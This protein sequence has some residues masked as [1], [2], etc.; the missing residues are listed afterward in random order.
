MHTAGVLAVKHCAADGVSMEVL[1]LFPRSIVV[2][3][4]H[5][6]FSFAPF[7]CHALL[8]PRSAGFSGA[9]RW[10]A[11]VLQ[12]AGLLGRR[13]C[14][15]GYSVWHRLLTNRLVR[16]HQALP[17]SKGLPTAATL[18]TLCLSLRLSWPCIAWFQVCRAGPLGWRLVTW[19][20]L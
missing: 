19:L 14:P 12:L 11:R 2:L 3:Q 7:E 8:S 1:Q 18:H 10:P 15:M 16:L 5:L 13:A 9:V 20:R 4:M 17:P 6:L